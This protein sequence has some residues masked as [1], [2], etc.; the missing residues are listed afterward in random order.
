ME[1]VSKAKNPYRVDRVVAYA[2]EEPSVGKNSVS[3]S[4]AA[5]RSRGDWYRFSFHCT[6]DPDNLEVRSLTYVIGERVPRDQWER[7][8]LFK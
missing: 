3:A 1:Q 4:G 7:Y 2:F 5:F 6:T 8:H